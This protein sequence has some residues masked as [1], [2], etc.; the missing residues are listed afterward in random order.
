MPIETNTAQE[1]WDE[2]IGDWGP[3][4]LQRIEPGP[5]WSHEELKQHVSE[6]WDD[7]FQAGLRAAGKAG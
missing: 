1:Y 3:D 6:A 5:Q 4:P 7:G 2:S